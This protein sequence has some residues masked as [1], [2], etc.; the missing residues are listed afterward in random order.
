MNKFGDKLRM[1]RKKR[2]LTL[3]Q[4][5]VQLEVHHTYISQL[6]MGKR[7]PNAAMILKIADLFQVTTD[8]LMRDELTLDATINPHTTSEGACS[9]SKP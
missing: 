5:G 6:E 9:E 2:N 1:L 4:L 8:Q 7:S 3:Q